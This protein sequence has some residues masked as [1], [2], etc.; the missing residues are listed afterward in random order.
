MIYDENSV[1]PSGPTMPSTVLFILYHFIL[2]VFYLAFYGIHL[3]M[4]LSYLNCGVPFVAPPGRCCS[5]CECVLVFQVSPLP[6]LSALWGGE[7]GGGGGQERQ[8]LLPHQMRLL[9]Q[10]QGGGQHDGEYICA[11]QRYIFTDCQTK[12]MGQTKIRQLQ[13]G[14]V[15]TVSN[16]APVIAQPFIICKFRY[17]YRSKYFHFE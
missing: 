16:P 9:R 3:V 6:L 2:F 11:N 15:P 10:Q 14:S 4:L 8:S 1:V 5:V 17:Q 7:G 12:E 13:P